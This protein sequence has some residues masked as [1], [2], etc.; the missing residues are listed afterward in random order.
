MKCEYCGKEFDSVK[1]RGRI[2]RY[3]SRVCYQTSYN[4]KRGTGSN[5][6]PEPF[7]K[8][9]VVCGKKFKTRREA[10]TTC[11]HECAMQKEKHRKRGGKRKYDHTWSEWVELQRKK[12]EETEAVKKIEKRFYKVAHTVERECVICG[13]V[14]YCLD[15]VDNKTCSPKCSKKLNSL[16]RDKRIPKER[17][18]DTDITNNRLY[19]RDNGICWLCGGLCEWEDVTTEGGKIRYGKKYPSIDHV[20]PISLGGIHSWDNVRLA[21]L[22]CNVDK[23]NTLVGFDLL[24]PARAYRCKV[25]PQGKRTIQKTLDGQV[26]K[27]WE[28]TAQIR[29][30]L[31]L[32][33]KH[34]QNVC[35]GEGKSAYGFLWEYE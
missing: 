9:C 34:I 1:K 19:V 33:D 23:G 14:F 17:I 27:V 21:H 20:I 31:K 4:L 18:V 8:E 12:K 10:T 7:T 15:K 29:R 13:T 28:S 24:D 30:E 22:G 32:S 26:V 11:S 35:R 5:P 3:C 6:N 16:K 2:K 25:K